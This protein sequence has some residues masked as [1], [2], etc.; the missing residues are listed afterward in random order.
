MPKQVTVTLGGR[1]YVLKEKFAGPHRE[2]RDRL[3]NSNVMKIFKSLD[4]AMAQLVAAGD[5]IQEAW[6]KRKT[7]ETDDEDENSRGPNL[8][9]F[10]DVIRILPIV[11]L[12]VSG[13]M[14]EVQ[15]LFFAYDGK[16]AADRKWILANVYESE[17]VDAFWEILIL[18]NPTLALWGRMT[19]R[20]AR[21]T[22]SSLPSTNGASG[23]PASGPKKKTPISS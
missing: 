3:D 8:N 11:V 10:V 23:L 14:N 12:G 22:E 7:P 4:G 9:Q 18:A 2:W 21:S 19:G 13:S 1:E 5:I 15:D 16:L 17:I 6:A 20:R